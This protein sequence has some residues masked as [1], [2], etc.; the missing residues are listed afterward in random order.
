MELLAVLLGFW[1]FFPTIAMLVFML[2]WVAYEKPGYYPTITLLAFVLI[3]QLLG[4]IP[5]WQSIVA[6]P[7]WVLACVAAYFALGFPYSLFELHR[8]CRHVAEEYKTAKEG[9]FARWNPSDVYNN[10]EDAW[11]E[12]CRYHFF[13]F[14]GGT[15]SIRSYKG[16]ILAWMTHWPWYLIWR[17]VHD[18]LK[19]VWEFIY[20]Q[21]Q[22]VYQ[23]VANR[24]F[25]D[26]LR[27][28]SSTDKS[29]K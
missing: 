19:E 10:A 11:V 5:I 13:Q 9:F 8:F 28:L 3:L 27:D 16:K 23:R 22:E 24:Y 4:K 21:F 2:A 15:F 1:V 18:L 17:L 6:H 12:A 25:A 26:I 20:S 14:S 7:L 29:K